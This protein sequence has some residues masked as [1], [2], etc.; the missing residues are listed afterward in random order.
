MRLGSIVLVWFAT[1]AGA[2]IENIEVSTDEAQLREYIGELEDNLH[3]DYKN[4]PVWSNS[5][6]EPPCLDAWPDCASG[7]IFSEKKK[8]HRNSLKVRLFVKR[9]VVRRARNTQTSNSV[10]LTR[11]KSSVAIDSTTT[12]WSVTAQ[13]SGGYFKAVGPQ[14]AQ[15]GVTISASYTNS[16]TTGTQVSVS[17][18]SSF[19]CPPLFTCRSE[20]WVTY[21]VISGYCEHTAKVDCTNPFRKNSFTWVEP[22]DIISEACQ[23]LVDWR[24]KVCQREKYCQVETPIM[25]GSEPY[26]TEVFFESPIMSLH[27]KPRITGY[28]SGNYLLGSGDYLYNPNRNG[29]NYWTQELGWHAHKVFPNLDKE[30]AQ[31]KHLVP[32]IRGHA[33][34]CY[35]LSTEE[36]YCPM[37]EGKKKYY[38]ESLGTYAKPTAPDPSV[39]DVARYLDATAERLQVNIDETRIEEIM[40]NYMHAYNTH[41]KNYT[42]QQITDTNGQSGW[43]LLSWAAA[44]KHTQIARLLVDTGRVSMNGIDEKNG[45]MLLSWAAANGNNITLKMLSD[46]GIKSKKRRRRSLPIQTGHEVFDTLMDLNAFN[47]GTTN[48]QGRSLKSLAAENGYE[49]IVNTIVGNADDKSVYR[50][51][52]LSWDTAEERGEIIRITL[53]RGTREAQ[54]SLSAASGSVDTLRLLD[55]NNSNLDVSD[56]QGRQQLWWAAANGNEAILKLL[57]DTRK[58]K[59][60]PKEAERRLFSAA[61]NSDEEMVKMLLDV[62]G[63]DLGTKN[64]DGY[65]SFFY[66]A[67]HGVDSIIKSYLATGKV[68]TETRGLNGETPLAWAVYAQNVAVV[69]LL[70]SNYRVDPDVQDNRGWTPLWLAAYTGNQA[71]L[72]LLLDTG[73]VDINVKAK[74]FDFTPLLVACVR[75]QETAVKMLIDTGK[76]DL[77]ARDRQGHT[78]LW[79][80]AHKGNVAIV[81]MLLH[82]DKADVNAKDKVFG[83]TPLL[84]AAY[85]QDQD[86]FRVLR[87]NLKVDLNARDNL[88]RTPLWV[89]A[90]KSNGA[91]MQL[92]LDTGRAD[93]NARDDQY[94]RTPLS[95]SVWKGDDVGFKLLLLTGKADP[96]AENKYGRT[97]IQDAAYR[98]RKAM[99][100]RLGR[101]AR[102]YKSRH[103]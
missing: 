18:S 3:V 35:H 5:I 14:F 99:S 37:N 85:K 24:D 28:K 69:R 38:T 64:D 42:S 7:L 89:A 58:I 96:Y 21:A 45:E 56:I 49:S 39:Q 88:G 47:L 63:I 33:R 54:I 41:A 80:A 20:I 9:Q 2:N 74:N 4:P 30:V 27:K 36:W 83:R 1:R 44:N 19:T 13:A 60:S 100:M 72:K 67:H 59:P 25:G 16:R 78:P 98:N 103:R 75:S 81:Q 48:D 84:T 95:L 86:V 12:G 43:M 55:I 17:D 66:A 6:S 76:A 15:T 46:V 50:Q 82:T 73:R 22:C 29:D 77:N 57:I 61:K 91:L 93:L 31:F 34:K 11:E 79:L 23:Q 71:I 92:L 87:A 26:V 40:V 51:V 70:L 62:D 32:K 65:T 8:F 68:D 53:K 102:T 94:G 90:H 97:P 52:S 101:Y 10:V